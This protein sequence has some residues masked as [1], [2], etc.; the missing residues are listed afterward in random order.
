MLGTDGGEGVKGGE[1]CCD[2]IAGAIGKLFG[3]FSNIIAQKLAA[4]PCK[5][6]I[7]NIFTMLFIIN[8]TQLSKNKR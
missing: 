4:V 6:Y 1:R 5:T 7:H 3:G 2:G 8:V